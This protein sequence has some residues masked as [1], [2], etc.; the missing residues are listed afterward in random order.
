M[1]PKLAKLFN[2]LAVDTISLTTADYFFID[3]GSGLL[4]NFK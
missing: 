1:E 3:G 2:N 4:L